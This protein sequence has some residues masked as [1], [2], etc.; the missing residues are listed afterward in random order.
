MQVV[1]DRAFTSRPTLSR[2][3]RGDPGVSAGIYA[4]VT[5]ALGLLDRLANVARPTDDAVGMARTI[6]SLPQRVRSRR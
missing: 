3:E 2:V 5:H 4:A 6:E 1:A